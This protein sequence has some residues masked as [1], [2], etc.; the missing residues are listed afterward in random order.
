MNRNIDKSNFGYLGADYQYKLAKCFIEEPQYFQQVYTIVDQN[1]F[2]E[3]LLRQFVGILKDYYSTSGGVMPSYSTMITILRQR[4]RVETDIEEWEE[5]IKILQNTS[6]EG[7]EWVKDN[8]TFFF[9]QQSVCKVANELIKAVSDGADRDEY[10]E[11]AKHLQSV[12]SV[13]TKEDEGFNPYDIIDIVMA[14]NANVSIPTGISGLD[15]ALNGG[16]DKKKLGLV[17]G[18]AG[19][20]KTT[21]GTAISSFAST[22]KCDLNNGN[23]YKVLQIVFED[24]PKD[25]AKKH[26][27]R[28]SQIEAKDITKPNFIEEARKAI[29]E[30]EDK[31]IFKEN[32]IV[33]KYKPGTTT[34]S[35]IENYLKKLIN[36]GFKPDLMVIDY[37][38]PIK[39]VRYNKSDSKWDMEENCMREIECIAE[40]YNLAIWLMTQG[41]KDSF[42]SNIVNMAQAGGSVTKV[43][44]GHVVVSIARTIEDQANN[45]AT[46]TILKSRQGGSGKIW[47][48]ITFNNGTNTI[49]CDEVV[50]Y[51]N[52]LMYDQFKA[53]KQ[54]SNINSYGQ[55]LV[56]QQ[57]RKA[58]INHNIE[59]NNDFD[60]QSSLAKKPIVSGRTYFSRSNAEEWEKNL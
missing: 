36:S 45:K 29:D 49:S 21:F 32:L 7:C 27:A 19:F 53:E 6:T 5:L 54:E 47:E 26:F 11:I 57:Q 15:E 9:R 33:K 22:Y 51:D 8:A 56:E 14:P 3:P 10:N 1:T 4:S 16:L 42:T 55:M 12:L 28:I 44:I 59:P 50:E 40:D 39:K 23:G 46:L 30:F 13:T 20:G 24:D 17:I 2:T 43:Q 58:S 48:G 25:I 41:N 52:S 31:E 35:D 60:K 34:V 37:F 38:E 18:S